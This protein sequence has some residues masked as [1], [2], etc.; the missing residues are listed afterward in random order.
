ML[1]QRAGAGNLRQDLHADA[2][3]RAVEKQS[4]V[5]SAKKVSTA[6]QTHTECKQSKLAD[7]QSCLSTSTAACSLACHKPS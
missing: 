3:L 4:V 6:A 5:Q 2:E 1:S 7:P